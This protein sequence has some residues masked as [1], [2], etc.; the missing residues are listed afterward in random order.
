MLNKKDLSYMCV[1]GTY[2]VRW[3]Q[4]EASLTLRPMLT[5]AR[6]EASQG[7]IYHQMDDSAQRLVE[8]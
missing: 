1:Q 3:S 5:S 4:V 6:N 7:V 8:A 2:Q